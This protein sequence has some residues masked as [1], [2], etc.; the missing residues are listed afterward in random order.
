MHQIEN[1]VS[2][3]NTDDE[4]WGAH[5]LGIP[6][7]LGELWHAEGTVLLT[8]ARSERG[9]ANH[10]EMQPWKGYQIHRQLP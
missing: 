1:L 4:L 2:T 5:V 8:A 6:H 9:E 3:Q 7:L 10:E